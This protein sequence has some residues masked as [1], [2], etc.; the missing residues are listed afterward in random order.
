M[1]K[2]VG[3]E[4]FTIGDP[5][6]KCEL[7]VDPLPHF[8]FSYSLIVDGKTLEKFTETQNRSLRSWACLTNG[9]R[10]RVVFG[11]YIT[12]SNIRLNRYTKRK[13]WYYNSQKFCIY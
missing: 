2:L 5:K 1:F 13:I 8:A 12:G 7:K 3:D 4:K 10:Y 6:V 9:K 11:M